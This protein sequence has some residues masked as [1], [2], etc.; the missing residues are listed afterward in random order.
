MPNSKPT[1]QYKRRWR[2]IDRAPKV[3]IENRVSHEALRLIEDQQRLEM[4]LALLQVIDW[5][6]ITVIDTVED[7]R[8]AEDMHGVVIGLV[9][10]W[11]RICWRK[12]REQLAV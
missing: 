7:R 10:S 1:K 3:R 2:V 4:A 8:F 5:D 11:Q 12:M 9:T 6:S